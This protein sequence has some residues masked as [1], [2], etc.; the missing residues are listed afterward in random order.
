MR[1]DHGIKKQIRPPA[2]RTT[3]CTIAQRRLV[4]GLGG[5]PSFARANAG[6]ASVVITVADCGVPSFARANAEDVSAARVTAARTNLFMSS[7]MAMI[8]Q[9]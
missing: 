4:E 5:V 3:G 8:G 1:G 6:D 2:K 9:P 7:S